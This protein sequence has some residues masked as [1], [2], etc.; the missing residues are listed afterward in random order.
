M[1][2]IMETN[3]LQAQY[4]AQ[5]KELTELQNQIKILKRKEVLL[6]NARAPELEKLNNN[7]EVSRTLALI[8]S[9]ELTAQKLIREISLLEK[10]TKHD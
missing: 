8:N 2:L 3:N 5:N 7:T 9:G 1:L 4:L 6:N 10:S